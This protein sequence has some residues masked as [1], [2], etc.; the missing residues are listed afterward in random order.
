MNLRRPALRAT[1]ALFLPFVLAATVAGQPAQAALVA[2]TNLTGSGAPALAKVGDRLY[3]GWTGSTGTAAAKVLNVGYST[4]Q[5]LHIVKLANNERT[6]QN[7]GPALVADPN[8]S[9]ILIAWADGRAR[10]TLT[11]SYFSGTAF[12]CRTSFI[13]ITT[14]HAP[15]LAVDSS[16]QTYLAWTDAFRHL[17]IALIDPGTCATTHAITM[18]NRTV[19]SQTSPY[20]PGLIF[21]ST[22]SLQ[23]LI[24][25][26]ADNPAHTV[27]VGAFVGS[28]SLVNV[29][30]PE[31]PVYPTSGPSLAASGSDLYIAVR[32]ADNHLYFGYSQGCRPTCFVASDIG[33]AVR[34]PIGSLASGFVLAY[35]NGAGNLEI[36][37]L[38]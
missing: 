10:N 1:L 35:F 7:E 34:S 23:L 18:R 13:G 12:S 38:L 37:S 11:M 26:A 30:N 28:A 9:G 32:G 14:P 20:G 3:V 33:T 36:Y 17:N 8:S 19:L 31:I 22:V 6:P 24:A 29:A 25:W 5:G 16:G 2:T 21:D 15:A 27:T 4:D